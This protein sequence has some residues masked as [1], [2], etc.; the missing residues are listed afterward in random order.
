MGSMQVSPVEDPLGGG[1][2]TGHTD[3]QPGRIVYGQWWAGG[4]VCQA[5]AREAHMQS[6]HGVGRAS[7]WC[8]VWGKPRGK[9]CLISGRG[10]PMKKGKALTMRTLEGRREGGRDICVSTFL[11]DGSKAFS[12]WPPYLVE[13]TER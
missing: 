1:S 9:C 7:P 11:S 6:G 8:G 3:G 13:N 2:P 12:R 5:P 4:G 10:T